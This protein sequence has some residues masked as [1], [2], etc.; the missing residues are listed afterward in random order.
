MRFGSHILE[1]HIPGL[2]S[3]RPEEAAAKS[4]P[5]IAR[6][7][8]LP[9][10]VKKHSFG[11]EATWKYEFEKHQITG[12]RGVYAAVSQDKGSLKMSVCFTDTGIS[13][14]MPRLLRLPPPAA[15]LAASLAASGAACGC[16]WPCGL[17][18]PWCSA[19]GSLFKGNEGGPKEWG[20]EHRST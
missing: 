20:F 18:H 19:A 6:L 3:G 7:R 13:R 2:S 14:L 16:L 9:V 17:A 5:A 10:S 1:H 11:E 12:W 15:S 4:A 8:P